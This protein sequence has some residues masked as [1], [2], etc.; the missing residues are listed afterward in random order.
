MD[1]VLAH[2]VPDAGRRHQDFERGDAA[3]AGDVA[4][5]LKGA[6]A[7]LG[8]D[9]LVELCADI[10]ALA[11]ADAIGSAFPLLGRLGEELDLVRAALADAVP[12]AAR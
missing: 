2:Q 5:H 9:G 11:G 1:L 7:T 8:G 10:E 12:G 3:A 6:A 4:H